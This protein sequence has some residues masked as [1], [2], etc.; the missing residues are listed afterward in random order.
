[1][2]YMY[3]TETIGRGAAHVNH[4]A[5]DTEVMYP[6]YTM[7]RYMYMCTCSANMNDIQMCK[8]CVSDVSYVRENN[9]KK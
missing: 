2:I 6:T 3:M 8:P 9:M 7:C 5:T 1:M 4:V